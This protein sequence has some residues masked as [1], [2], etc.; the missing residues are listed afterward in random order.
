M[1]FIFPKNYRFQKKLLGII[2]YT[3]AI[4][5]ASIGILLFL[6]LNTFFTNINIKI[7]IFIT[8]YFPI[9]LFSITGT[10]RENVIHVFMYT[11][12]FLTNQKI[13]LFKKN[14]FIYK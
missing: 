3:T 2:D 13:Y 6:L 14:N 9:I 11:L 12:K 10:Y 5:D 4:L 1:H 7:Y 8:L